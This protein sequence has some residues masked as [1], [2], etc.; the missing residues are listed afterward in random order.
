MFFCDLDGVLR[1]LISGISV[2]AGQSYS[3]EVHNSLLQWEGLVYGRKVMDWINDIPE[4]LYISRPYPG[5]ERFISE[6]AKECD[7][8]ILTNQSPNN[9]SAV[10]PWLSAWGF[11]PVLSGVI[12][13]SKFTQKLQLLE[14][15]GPRFLLDDN[16]KMIKHLPQERLLS[17]KRPWNPEGLFESYNQVLSYIRRRL[18]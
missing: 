15:K 16:P 7:V 10:I 6:L 5:A 18:K 11:L 8:F 12:I 14:G 4:V 13:V 3:E 17:W 2:A 9:Y 1:N